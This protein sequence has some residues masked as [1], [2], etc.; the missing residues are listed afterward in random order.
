MKTLR[1]LLMSVA[2]LSVLSV[3]AQVRAQDWGKLPQIQMQSTSVMVCSGS[4][5]PSAAVNGVVVTGNVPGSYSPAYASSR[6]RR[7][8]A[9]G[10]GVDDD[11]EGFDDEGEGWGH[12]GDPFDT[13]LGDALWS[14]ALLALVFVVGKWTAKKLNHSANIN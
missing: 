4:T 10:N 3:S 6:P 13:P 8:D 2:I 7:I 14:L 12:T 9:N 5:L 11:D 1:Y